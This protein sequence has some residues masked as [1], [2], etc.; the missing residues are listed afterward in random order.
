MLCLSKGFI[1]GVIIIVIN[2]HQGAR[3]R[4]PEWVGT[5]KTVPHGKSR[6]PSSSL[7][8]KITSPRILLRPKEKNRTLGCFMRIFD[9]V[10]P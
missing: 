9:V 10:L 5:T 1:N 7:C 3:P 2:I 4:G 6:R 8:I